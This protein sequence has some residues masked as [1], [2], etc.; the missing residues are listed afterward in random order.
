MSISRADVEDNSLLDR[1]ILDY[2]PPVC[3]VCSSEIE[4]T[5]DLTNI[6]CVNKQC[7][8][9]VASRL[10]A[11][12]RDMK[13]DGWGESTCLKAVEG[14]GLTSPYQVFLLENKELENIGVSSLEKKIKAICSKDKRKLKLWE[15]VKV[16]NIPSISQV[17]YKL[18]NGFDSLSEAYEHIERYQVPFI[19][20]RL[21]LRDSESSILAVRVYNTLLGYKEEL[22]LGEKQFTVYKPEGLRLSVVITDNI[23]KTEFISSLNKRYAGKIYFLLLNTVSSGLDILLTNGDKSSRKYKQA[24]KLKE[25]N[26]KIQ[27]LNTSEIFDY[28]D[29]L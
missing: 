14:Y 2:I 15:M 8:L 7:A 26:N 25:E 13:V 20:D 19:A 10:E 23:N 21:G 9:K 4:F 24:L 16:G 18:F 6:Y 28:L 12:A 22:L 17:A 27:I 5:D 1:E 3:P 11:M 29:S